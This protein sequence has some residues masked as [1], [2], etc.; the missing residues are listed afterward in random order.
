MIQAAPSEFAL[1]IAP[2]LDFARVTRSRTYETALTPEQKLAIRHDP[3][4]YVEAGGT[5]DHRA[6]YLP[7][8]D[9]GRQYIP[10]DGRPDLAAVLRP[11]DYV[12]VCAAGYRATR[13][14]L[15]DGEVRLL[16]QGVGMETHY[17]VSAVAVICS[18]SDG[19]SYRHRDGNPLNL[20]RG[21]L[22]IQTK[23]APAQADA[24]HCSGRNKRMPSPAFGRDAWSEQQIAQAAQR[25]A[26]RA[27]GLKPR[28]KTRAELAAQ[29]EAELANIPKTGKATGLLARF[30]AR[31]TL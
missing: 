20:L 2:F 26:D 17:Y 19:D 15:V 23:T 21:N 6:I 10:I 30:E 25:E 1:K 12:K 5:L 9:A 8:R 18:L 28:R 27:A 14:L 4:G 3:M 16:K 13:W 24:K 22:I 11:D 29:R 7:Y 31:G